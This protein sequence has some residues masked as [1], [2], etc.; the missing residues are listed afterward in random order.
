MAV[1]AQKA[2]WDL[3]FNAEDLKVKK[4]SM[5]LAEKTEAD[6]E[7]QVRIGTM[8]PID[9][10]QSQSEVAT[11]QEALVV[12]TYTQVQS[13]DQV[14]KLITS[15]SDPGM[16]L[17][18]LTPMQPARRLRRPAMFRVLRTPSGLLLENRPEMRQLNVDLKNK[19][20]DVQYT[21]NQLL[22]V[23]DVSANYSQNAIG[24]PQV[25]RIAEPRRTAQNPFDLMW[26]LGSFLVWTRQYV[27]SATLWLQVY[28]LSG[29]VYCAD[30]PDQS[31]RSSR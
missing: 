22:P 20:I 4:R 1:Q 9:V 5:D 16:I 15:Q 8:A 13:E 6:N 7:A 30:S 23:V 17:A 3:V 27:R 2:Y 26:V 11:R 19:D 10:I 14:K 29:W 21:K 25:L 12:S 18:R 24:G 28:R 31:R